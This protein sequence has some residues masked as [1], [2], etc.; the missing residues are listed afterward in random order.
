[1]PSLSTAALFAFVGLAQVRLVASAQATSASPSSS[2]WTATATATATTSSAVQ[3]HTITVGKG[4][5]KFVPDVVLANVGDIIQ[6]QF[7]PPNH[8][9]ARA[10]YLSPCIPYEDTGVDKVGFF[11]GFQAVDAVLNNP[12]TYS[13]RVNDT[14]PVFFYCTAP[15][16]CINYGMVGVINPVSLLQITRPGQQAY[17]PQNASVSLAKQRALAMGAAYM[18]Q[19]GESFPAEA[20]SSIAS[21]AA[22]TTLL[23]AT[24]PTRT[25]TTTTNAAVPTSANSQPSRKDLSAGAIAGIAVGGAAVLALG[26]ALCFL[27]GRTKTLKEVIDNNEVGANRLSRPDMLHSSG[28]QFMPVTPAGYRKSGNAPGDQRVQQSAKLSRVLA[29]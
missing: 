14:N 24:P 9:V 16:S 4:D 23:T 26:A 20:S 19:P 17:P 10:E 13:L 2:F 18:L 8:S 29:D 25:E 5:N 1:M 15:G 21:L 3:T 7:F 12:P 11:S 22:A 28:A 6:S 27:L